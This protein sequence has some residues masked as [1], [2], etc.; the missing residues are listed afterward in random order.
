MSVLAILRKLAAMLM[1]GAG[2][3]TIHGKLVVRDPGSDR[4]NQFLVEDKNGAPMLWDNMFGLQSGGEPVCAMGLNLK[5]VIC[6][7]GRFG[8]YGVTAEV[9]YYNASGRI[10]R[11]TR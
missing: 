6:L 4:G 10:V 1:I 7:G 2:A 9:V 11:I 8:Q 5:P 3:V